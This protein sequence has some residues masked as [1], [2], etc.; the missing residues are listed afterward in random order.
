MDANQQD[1]HFKSTSDHSH[2]SNGRAAGWVLIS[3]IHISSP[4]QTTHK[5]A[6]GEQQDGCS[7][8]GFTFQVH[9]RP[10]TSYQWESSRM[11]AD[12]QDSHFMST[13][14]HSPTSNGRAAGWML[15]SRIHISSPHQTTHKL[16]MGEQQDGC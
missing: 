10:L 11:D 2:S 4:H 8:A 7:S 14:D 15:I 16:A 1:S 12:Q 13:S 3:R 9:I 6:M 5:L